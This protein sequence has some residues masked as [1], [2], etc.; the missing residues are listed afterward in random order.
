M[1]NW[2]YS[3]QTTY[4]STLTT[5]L[6]SVRA[7]YANTREYQCSAAPED[8]QESA[9]LF[10]TTMAMARSQTSRRELVCRIRKGITAWVLSAATLT[11]TVGLIFLW[12]TTRRRTSCTITTETAPLR[13][14]ALHRAPPLMR[15]AASRAVWE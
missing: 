1:G 10:T 7:G 12:L 4:S 6:N 3:S 5:C 9:I 2:I 15:T 13:R 8:Y 14:L 11:K